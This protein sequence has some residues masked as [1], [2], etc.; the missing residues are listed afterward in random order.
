MKFPTKTLRHLLTTTFAAAA[1][2]FALAGASVANAANNPPGS[3]PSKPIYDCGKVIGYSIGCIEFSHSFG[4]N[5]FDEKNEGLIKLLKMKP[6]P[7]LYDPSVLYYTGAE[8]RWIWQDEMSGDTRTFSLLDD[9]GQFVKYS[10]SSA[11]TVGLPQGKYSLS[12]T[13]AYLLDSNG[14]VVANS[15]GNNAVYFEL[16]FSD[17]SKQRYSLTTKQVV[18]IGD[19]TGRLVN[20]ADVPDVAKI[21]IV[22]DDNCLRQI[23][24]AEGVADI[25]RLADD[26]GFV[27]KF[28]ATEQV[29][30]KT[31]GLYPL[32]GSPFRTITFDNPEPNNPNPVKMRIVDV[33]GAK[34]RQYLFLYQETLDDWQLTRGEGASKE[35]KELISPP[36][37]NPRVYQ[38]ILR[39]ASGNL[40]SKVL[41]TE[42]TGAWG[43]TVETNKTID[44]DGLNYQTNS[45]YNLTAG[46]AGY[47]KLISQTNPNGSWLRYTYDAQNRQS[48]RISPWLDS[49]VGAAESAARVTEYQ[50]ASHD[51]TD[52][53]AANDSRPRTTIERITG[54]ITSRTYYVYGKN[55]DGE[56]YEITERA[57]TQ[58]AAYGATG[59]L[60]TTT[61]YYNNAA[62]IAGA[63]RVKTIQYPNNTLT[64][65]AYSINNTGTN[66]NFVTT[67][68]RGTIS[69]PAGVANKTLRRITTQNAAGRILQEET[70]VYTGSVYASLNIVQRTYSEDGF[71]TQT[72]KDGR[73]IYNATYSGGLRTSETNETGIVKNYTYD[74]LD[75]I[76]TETKV[77]TGT[78]PDIT[79]TYNRT[80]GGLDC[81]CDANL[82]VT[83]SAGELSLVSSIQ[84]NQI[85]QITQQ[86][87]TT[88]LTTSTAYT[89]GG[90]T[91]TT[92]KP[93]TAVEIHYRHLDGQIKSVTGTGIIS[94][95]MSYN[96]NADGTQWGK[97]NLLSVD[98][99]RWTKITTDL[100]GR[101]IKTERPGYG[102]GTVIIS[103]LFYNNF[104]QIASQS[105]QTIGGILAATAKTTTFT[106]DV[107]GEQVSSSTSYGS[108]PAVTTLSEKIYLQ[109]N[110]VWFV[111]NVSADQFIE[112][113]QQQIVISNISRQQ[114]SEFSD[115]TVSY[116]EIYAPPFTNAGA[117]PGNLLSVF[118]ELSTFPNKTTQTTTL[119]RGAKTIITTT[120]LPTSTQARID[121]S[122]NGFLIYSV[123]PLHGGTILYQYDAL[124]RQTGEKQPRHTNYSSVTYNAQGQ[125]SATADAAG[126][127]ITYTYYANGIVGAGQLS[128]ATNTLGN[129]AYYHYDLY[130]RETQTWGNAVY[131]SIQGYDAYGERNLLQTF[132]DASNNFSGSTF[133]ASVTADTTTWTYDPATGLLLQK[134][135]ANG[136]GTS[137]DYYADGFL[138]RR[139]WAR[140]DANNNNL[141]TDYTYTS[142]GQLA[143]VDYSDNTP[144]VS[145]AYNVLGQQI[146]VTD[147]SGTRA[148]S[149]SSITQL[150]VQETFDGVVTGVLNRS[151]DNFNRP[152][153][154]VLL[155]NATTAQVA[156]AATYDYDVLGNF[157][158]I[159]GDAVPA[160]LAASNYN[161]SSLS[162]S[163]FTYNRLANSELLSSVVGPVHTVTNTYEPN[164]DI[165]TSKQ[166]RVIIGANANSIVSQYDYTTDAVAQHTARSQSGTAFAAASTDTF[167]YNSRG[168]V[169]GSANNQTAADNRVYAYDAIGN[170]LSA[171]EGASA[172][173]TDAK[174]YISNV[175]NQYTQI[176]TSAQSALSTV[177][178]TYDDDGNMLTDGTGK[179]Y[180]WDCEN[181]L[182]RVYLQNNTVVHYVYDGLS[183]MVKRESLSGGN[184][185]TRTTYIY[186]G[187]NII[188]EKRSGGTLEIIQEKTYLWGI[189]LGNNLKTAAG[190]G[191][192]LVAKHKNTPQGSYFY[193]YDGNGNV[194]EI[195]NEDGITQASYNYDAFGRD[196]GATG[197]YASQNYFRFA[198]KIKDD[199]TD[200]LN[201]GSRYYLPSLGRWI[202]RDVIGEL[203]GFN[204]YTFTLN[205]C[206]NNWDYLGFLCESIYSE[207]GI[208]TLSM[209]F[210]ENGFSWFSASISLAGGLKSETKKCTEQC[211]PSGNEA[212]SFQTSIEASLNV[213]VSGSAGPQ[214]GFKMGEVSAEASLAIT[215]SA[216]ASASAS[217]ELKSG[218][219]AQKN[220]TVDIPL[221]L[222][223]T[224]ELMGGGKVMAKKGWFEITLA[225]ATA[226][227]QLKWDCEYAF[228]GC[229]TSGCSR[230]EWR[231]CDYKGGKASVTF[232]VFGIC[233]EKDIAKF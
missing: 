222:S 231:G 200:L 165:L 229:T 194:K 1:F 34:T 37:E 15:A 134:T 140:K 154:Y 129:I 65:Y 44:P 112:N 55:S 174:T 47:S 184:V 75:R 93:N 212:T 160:S 158:Q 105:V 201:Y 9:N 131:P 228:T 23:K 31:D 136:K 209:R 30:T 101:T 127:S 198:T 74:A 117:S 21:D 16:R 175:I 126:N 181:R 137:Y 91:T 146:S 216:K 107:L 53:V 214:L 77:G 196:I 157:F 142:R 159:Q 104:G 169:I 76:A 59:N 33:W 119:N 221:K 206:V 45:T 225:R 8:G 38:R 199:S 186:D 95:Y 143:G 64:T 103:A 195:I 172:N 83:V 133:P 203:G 60:R 178:P 187:W 189:E 82:Q 90:R 35:A 28:Y 2:A 87:D 109:D 166:N 24:A 210:P 193:T 145:F 46:T 149:Y 94:Q 151:Y 197:I 29:G 121:A 86:T 155:S 176:Q 202:N 220:E 177:N 25:T 125:V 48:K 108:A 41:T 11:A 19:S 42:L 180:Q 57:A 39:D 162:P 72:T 67:E 26:T 113:A 22:K 56:S 78:Q 70:Q 207:L 185:L 130:G 132:R 183:R 224:L 191:G 89:N 168:E 219:C 97:T 173:P 120:Q 123:S 190:I 102:A 85:G 139:T 215:L 115:N 124:G 79:T 27:I 18:A 148:L 147:G 62:G 3:D 167:S 6:T 232:C 128:S 7:D 106:Y 135:Y 50:Y 14:T 171:Y 161:T 182:V 118:S 4:K 5:V 52:I 223:L 153:G 49:P 141:S 84:K 88:G 81:G 192:L 66:C 218:G 71:L 68:T 233:Y 63:G 204:L 99:A 58:S 40:V 227:G 51:S 122:C 179:T 36:G 13:R 150:L 211:C 114:I 164:R 96:I 152:T 111:A 230:S 188:D 208:P 92:L 32:S 54:I 156:T 100:L 226:Q 61:T 69:S 43:G 98:G 144:D 170:R 73:T 12:E 116:S 138:K 213:T 20:L 163:S 17:T 217:V 110:S 205:D 10:F 80:L